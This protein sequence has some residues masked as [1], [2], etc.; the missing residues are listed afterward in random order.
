[1]HILGIHLDAPFIRGALLR[2]ERKGIEIS[3]LKDDL[4]GDSFSH[5]GTPNIPNVKQLYIRG[6]RI[7]SGISAKDFLMRPLKLNIASSRYIEEAIAF[8][9]EA[10]SHFNPA[11]I[12]SVPLVQQKGKGTV[13]A[14]LFTV[15]RKALKNH[16]LTLEGL[17]IDPDGVSALPLALCHFVRWKFPLL[18][19]AFLIDLGSSETTCALLENGQLKKAHVF[20]GG[21]EKLLSALWED[22]KKILLK[23]E[24]EGAAKQIDLLLLK[25]GLNPHLSTNLSQLRQEVAKAFHSFCREA[26]REVIFTGRSD[27][28]IHLRE[29]LMEYSES[30]WPL[31]L[32]EQKFAISIG[33][34]L[35]Q[36]S[37]QPLQLRR[38]EFF[39]RKNWSQMGFYALLLLISSTLLSG[40]LFGFGIRSSS[41]QKGEMLRSLAPSTEGS[42]EEQIDHWIASIEK[43]D[44]E[45]RFIHQAPKV[46]EVFSWLSAH[47]LL[48]E[49]KKEGDPIEVQG[50]RYQLITLPKIDA[51]KDPYLA[52]VEIEFLFKSAMNARKFHEA[53]R[54][55][56]DCVDPTLEMTW[57]ALNEGYRACFFLKNRSPYVP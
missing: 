54:K 44:R 27:A 41:V 29:F 33:L 47:P 6:A 4:L 26:K 19:D 8:Q 16:L 20:V 3:V 1:M 10:I 32:E 37:P 2:K 17:Q 25:P 12:L 51:P 49:L 23:K 31:T 5:A 15:P 55:G 22:R 24:I 43:N 48:E 11:D 52:K 50:I 28:F 21:I 53:L 38:E 18:S 45:Y 35:E 57:D 56:D 42:V 46:I 39:P 40:I 34:A 7:A 14:L 30:K 9:S 13:E 36:T